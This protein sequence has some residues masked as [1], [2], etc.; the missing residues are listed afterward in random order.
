MAP[1]LA[2][3]ALLLGGGAL[4]WFLATAVDHLPTRWVSRRRRYAAA[5]GA[6]RH[7]R[8][9]ALWSALLLAATATLLALLYGPGWT[10]IGY[11]LLAAFMLLLSLIDLRYRVVPNAL[12]YPAIG[13]AALWA[14]R[15]GGGAAL[16][17]LLGG[18]VAGL[19]FLAAAVTSRS[20]L[21]GGDIKLAAFIG[22]LFGL[23]QLFTALLI[24]VGTGALVAVVLLLVFHRPATSRI[25]FGPYLCLGAV[26]ALLLQPLW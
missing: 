12:I 25:A 10:A 5:D 3:A 26:A 9:T 23:P 17:H 24:G 15:P 11:S 18:L 7:T 13:G 22:L 14:L 2:I 1:A 20:G 16:L 21:G 6:A 4:G 19:L 8:H